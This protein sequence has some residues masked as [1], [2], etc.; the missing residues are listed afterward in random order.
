MNSLKDWWNSLSASARYLIC[1]ALAFSPIVVQLIFK[2]PLAEWVFVPAAIW[3]VSW[4]GAAY[5][6]RL[7][8]T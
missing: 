7:R 6:I 5:V 2:F 8:N 4:A 1:M 3:C